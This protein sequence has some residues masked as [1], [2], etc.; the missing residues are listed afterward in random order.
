MLMGVDI[1]QLHL[2][3]HP[4]LW[5]V[6]MVSFTASVFRGNPQPSIPVHES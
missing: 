3:P 1:R 5:L 4:P 2:P 6:I